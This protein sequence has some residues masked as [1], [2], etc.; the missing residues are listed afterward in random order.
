[1]KDLLFETIKIKNLEIKNRIYMPAMHLQMAKNFE[2]TDQLI[3]FYRER[4]KGGAGMI[5]VGYATVND[6]AGMPSCIGAHKDDYIPGLNQLASVIKDNG[7]RAGVQLNHSGRYNHSFFLNGRQPVAPSPIPSRLTKETPRELSIDEIKETINSFAEATIRIKKAGFEAVEVLSGTG[8]LISEFMSPLTNQRKDEYGGS[9]ENRIRFGLEIMQAIKKS[10]GD[11]FPLIVRMNGNDF[12]Q[13]GQGRKELQ[14]YAKKLVEVGVDA[15]CINV[16][17]HE[18]RVPQIVTSVPRGAF[19]YLSRGIKEKVSV[20]VIASHRIPDPET[21]R[22]LLDN[23]MCDMIAMGRSLIAD[24]YMPEKARTGR[25]NE[26]IHCIA[27]AQGCFDNLFKMKSVEC[28]CNPVS[29]YEKERKIERAEKAKKIMIVGGG[30]GGMSAAIACAKRGYY[31]TLYDK[32]SRL[33]GQLHIAG[34]PPGREEFLRLAKDLEAQLYVNNVKVVLNQNVD[35]ELIK[36]EMPDAVIIATGA[37]PIKP[38]ITGIDLPNVVQSWDVLENK[39]R[40]GKKVV[41]IGG[42]AVGVETALFLAEK[43]T[44]PP[45]VL[46]FLMVNKAEDMESLYELSIKGT[47]DV[48]LIEMID[49]VGKDIGI[50]TRWGMLQD[51]GRIGVKTCISTKALEITENSIKVESAGNVSEIPADTIVLAVGALPYNPIQSI[52]EK[53]NISFKV[54]GDAKKIGMAFDAVHQGFLAGIAIT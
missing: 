54:I 29:G 20:P 31:V 14:E 39:V 37:V 10:T 52:L 40:T 1:M 43:G 33:G 53:M 8:Y 3:N 24:P 30:P 46:K 21:A 25:E 9:F 35:E 2:I 36:Q 26:I 47:K 23:N 18:A 51:L 28:M 5:I 12:M 6:L 15:L 32:G 50:T 7:A 4:A 11:D 41:V 38:R 17:W 27:C 16:G 44:L 45:D 48:L 34:A 13:G 19:A 49:K 42:G 22:E